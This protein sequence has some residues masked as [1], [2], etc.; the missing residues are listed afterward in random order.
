MSWEVGNSIWLESQFCTRNC[1]ALALSAE[2]RLL[3]EEGC[4]RVR[5][6]PSLDDSWPW[7][8]A[9]TTKI[10]NLIYT[11][12]NPDTAILPCDHNIAITSTKC[13]LTLD[14]TRLCK[15]LQVP[16]GIPTKP[17]YRKVLSVRAAKSFHNSSVDVRL[18]CGIFWYL[19]DSTFLTELAP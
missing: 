5:P 11:N 12:Y 17:T 2:L 19:S 18:A 3:S 14:L 9:T 13:I 6:A 4:A 16:L 8:A 10:N 15:D 1:I 7:G